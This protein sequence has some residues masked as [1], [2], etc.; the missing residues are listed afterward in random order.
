M[1]RGL[2]PLVRVH[3]GAAVSGPP[4]PH[5]EAAELADLAPGA[6]ALAL[7]L[8]AELAPRWTQ[9][10]AETEVARSFDPR[11]RT[12]RESAWTVAPPP[13]A[14]RSRRVELIVEASNRA[15]LEAGR[16]SGAD[17]IVLDLDDTFAPT[18]VNVR[19]AYAL[20]RETRAA[21]EP[22]ILRPRPLYLRE[23][24]FSFEEAPAIAAL[25]D[26]SVFLAARRDRALMYLPKLE[27][28]AE[29]RFWDDALT[30]AERTLGLAPNSVR[31][32]LQIETLPAAF[33]AEEL[34]YEL[35]ARAFGLNAGRWDYVFSLIKHL[36]A[37]PA[38]VLPGRGGLGMDQDAMLAYAEHLAAVCARRGAQAVGGSAA[39]VPD[40]ARPEVAL[41]AVRADKRREA[42]QGYVA[43]WAG[44]PELV[45]AVR[46][47]F[48]G[49]RASAVSETRDEAALQTRLLGVPQVRTI[50]V[51]A[52]REAIGIAVDYFDAWRAGRGWIIRGG[53]VE[54]TATA[55]L[56]RAQ[57]WQWARH[58]TPLTDG[59][60]LDAGTYLALRREARPDGTPAATLLDALV[61][62]ERCR[63]YFPRVAAELEAP[64]A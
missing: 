62:S 38:F 47:G 64:P 15:A 19:A 46:E 32:C 5:V 50:A 9:L 37:D 10:Q 52:V 43:A 63:D 14:L 30:L 11:S 25:L 45:P 54:D 53:R 2:A 59:G 36:G 42:G 8:H 27:R 55:E 24:S 49:S 16:A 21:P 23:R 34:L 48:E 57:L 26:L 12:L 18:P 41:A 29:A 58:R 44:L 20:I 60:E 33:L 56:A 7:A 40:P 35:R 28:V 13:R 4:S 6:P 39:L 22:L 3:R 51:D 1:G 61:L 17:A 31:V